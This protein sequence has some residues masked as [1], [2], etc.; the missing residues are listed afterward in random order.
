MSSIPFE[1]PLSA[2]C[3]VLVGLRS[4]AAAGV[5]PAR[6]PA[7]LFRAAPASSGCLRRPR[8]PSAS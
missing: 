7:S 3:F 6:H 4:A 8:P 2:S 5:R 1:A